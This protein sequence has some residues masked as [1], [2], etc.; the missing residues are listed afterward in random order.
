MRIDR[1]P[2]YGTNIGL[3]HV[4]ELLTT[5]PRPIPVVFARTHYS[6]FKQFDRDESGKLSRKEFQLALGAVGLGGGAPGAGSTAG[7]GLTRA[8]VDKF[9]AEVDTDG[10]GEVSYEEFFQF[11]SEYLDDGDANPDQ[12]APL[13]NSFRGINKCK[14]YQCRF[15][16]EG[17]TGL[18]V[19]RSQGAIQVTRV[20]GAALEM[21]ARV[22]D[23]ITSIGRTNVL[24][25]SVTKQQVAALLDGPTAARPVRVVLAT[26]YVQ[27]FER[28][29]LDGS[30][31][32][33]SKEFEQG[34]A[35]MGFGGGYS[36]EGI[37]EQLMEKYDLSCDG[38]IDYLEFVALAD[39]L[40]E[41]L[42]TM[43]PRAEAESRSA[44]AE[45]RGQAAKARARA[46]SQTEVE[47]EELEMQRQAKAEEAEEEAKEAEECA[48]LEAAA[49]KAAAAEARAEQAEAE[50]A[51]LE[52]AAQAEADEEE[53]ERERA[54]RAARAEAAEAAAAAAERVAAEH[55]KHAWTKYDVTFSD[56][57]LGL[58]M[59][60]ELVDGKTVMQIHRVGGWAF[61]SGVRQGDVIMAIEGQ[62]VH[63]TSL[64]QADAVALLKGAARP[65]VVQFARTFA[66]F[67]EAFDA[68]MSG[69]I[70]ADEFH[71]A[72][73]AAGLVG[74]G[75]GAGG[76]LESAQAAEL[77]QDCDVD[78]DG[79]IS[80]REFLRFAQS[81]LDGQGKVASEALLTKA[82][83][84]REAVAAA[85]V[86]AAAAAEA[87]AGSS[88]VRCPT[89]TKRQ[90]CSLPGTQV[91]LMSPLPSLSLTSSSVSLFAL[92]NCLPH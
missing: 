35:E 59:G 23:V 41:D 11:A 16:E 79:A 2:V 18:E 81:F 30:G 51:A 5:L 62:P 75:T 57:P 9:L 72:L 91:Q 8:A 44:A 66:G 74:A 37:A 88:I 50:Q 71:V 27:M 64:G 26:T 33:T 42:K 20:S 92:N 34:L 67:F 54:A 55:E 7:R 73:A 60:E 48:I 47:E 56:G 19:G 76:G 10:D 61:E 85:E 90:P 6:S 70:D 65:M 49:A 4:V 77:L 31:F 21:G 78:G 84:E 52:V 68:D 87:A 36:V 17:L 38:R 24:G 80:Y 12:A 58:T 53:A 13:S 63:G 25:T 32:V 40:A 22:G 29:D 83:A 14:K 28:F 3:S 86:A 15:T 1:T 45:E 82:A 69:K 89:Q 46:A 39:E 43:R